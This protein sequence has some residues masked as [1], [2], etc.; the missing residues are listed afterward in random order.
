M[1]IKLQ[2][3]HGTASSW[4]STN[5]VLA[6]GEKGVETD[7]GQFK[8]GD[9]T[10]AWASLAYSGTTGATQTAPY[11]SMGDG[12]DG[13]VTI[14]SG[15]TTLTRDMFYNNLTL[16]G[17]GILNTASFRVFVKGALDI[18]AAAAGAIQLSGG[19]G[20]NAS[21]ATGGTAGTATNQTGSVGLGGTAGAGSTATTGAGT[22]G[23]AGGGN[24]SPQ[25]G[26]TNGASG[27]GGA[28]TNAAGAGTAAIGQ[29]QYWPIRRWDTTLMGGA[30][31]LNGGTGGRG[32]ASG[33][34]DG[35]N[36]AGGGGGSGA[37]GGVLALYVN[38]IV[39]SSSTLAGT[40]QANGGN[41]GNGANGAAGNTGGG[42]GGSGAGGGWV[43]IAYNQAFGPTVS[44]LIQANGG[45]GGN[46]GNGTGTG[47]GGDG[48]NAG[49]P[50]NITLVNVPSQSG[51]NYLGIVNLTLIP[52]IVASNNIGSI[53][54]DGGFNSIL[55]ADF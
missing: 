1:A 4:T 24:I 52:E 30:V 25:N 5:P 44:N 43:Y 47:L 55:Q 28:G 14:S 7:T 41:G 29:Q 37:G 17:S 42:G 9:G 23:G 18:S 34:G 45:N 39:K 13:N 10:T 53:G 38:T 11:R 50:G 36:N 15:T 33:G 49:M 31:V 12:S 48:G 2:W 27:D 22:A 46:G 20:G 35:T 51:K 3:R 40:I 8:I 26:G 32:G 16:S 54:G 21:G 19:N 6:Q